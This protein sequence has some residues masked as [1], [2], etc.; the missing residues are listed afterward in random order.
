[1]GGAILLGLLNGLNIAVIGMG[2]VLIFK[3][4]KYINLAQAQLGIVPM[5][6]L[7]KVCI[8]AH[9]NWY[10]G[11]AFAL[12]VG[13][14]LGIIFETLIV[15]PL[16][17]L[18]PQAVLVGTLGVSQVLIGLAYVKQ[19]SAK[20]RD[21]I[22][23]GYPVPFNTRFKI[24]GATFFSQHLL[25]I[26]VV[27]TVALLLWIFLS[28]TL[29]GKSIR[30]TACNTQAAQLAGLSIRR[31]SLVAWSMAGIMA[32]IGAILAAPN[33]PAFDPASVGPGLMFAEIGRAHV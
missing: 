22:A 4:G 1:M 10:L 26:I 12:V 27:P 30:A 16:S 3:T 28:R 7:G 8:D 5:L 6:L 2:I 19:L 15:R 25:T 32:A 11:F 21:L 31:L 23:N 24:A 13:A 17:K 33:S 18:G 9:W 14:L 29:T 20:Q